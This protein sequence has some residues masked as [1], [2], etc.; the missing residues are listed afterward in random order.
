MHGNRSIQTKSWPTRLAPHAVS[1]PSPM[2]QGAK[3][4][5][6]GPQSKNKLDVLRAIVLGIRWSLYHQASRIWGLASTCPRSDSGSLCP[7]HL[8][9]RAHAAR[10][11]GHDLLRV[12]HPAT[13]IF[14]ARK[15]QKPQS[16]STCKSSDETCC[17][18]RWVAVT[19][20]HGC[21]FRS[22][23][24]PHSTLKRRM[25]DGSAVML[26]CNAANPKQSEARSDRDKRC[27]PTAEQARVGDAW[28]VRDH[29]R[30]ASLF[31]S[32]VDNRHRVRIQPSISH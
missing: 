22:P 20:P 1:E 13:S 19:Q 26:S 24:F 30:S 6:R 7:E 18:S 10:R 15:T 29:G 2:N 17:G 25:M 9:S 21:F 3:A 16:E 5:A 12:A 4:V 31:S 27:K 32:S 23:L 11:S 14:L 28:D 8:Q